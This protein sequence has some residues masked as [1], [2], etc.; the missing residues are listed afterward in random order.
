MKEPGQFVYE[1]LMIQSNVIHHAYVNGVKKLLFLSSACV[2]PR[3]CPQPMKEEHLLTGKFEPTNEAYAVAKIAGMNM[4]ASYNRQYGT[5]YFGVI[6]INLYGINDNFDPAASHVVPALMKRFHD[7]KV[8]GDKEVSAWGTGTSVREFMDADDCADACYFLME[9][10]S[11]SPEDVKDGIVFFNIG[12]GIGTTIKELTEVIKEVVGFE[13]RIAWDTSKPDGMPK[14]T[15]DPARIAAMGWEPHI[16]L[17]EGLEKM[18]QW[19]ST[20][21]D[22]GKR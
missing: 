7:A 22:P 16:S 10:Y 8:N 11:P 21:Y 1:N 9:Q 2:Y 12:N 5:Q 13:G 20:S 14:K 4:C 17:R 19:Y 15:L 6:P 3:L 18:Y